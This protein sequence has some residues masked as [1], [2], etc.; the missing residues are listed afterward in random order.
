MNPQSEVL[1][2]AAATLPAP[3]LFRSFWMGGF[4]CATHINVF[5]QR[6]D[7]IAGVQHDTK[8]EEDYAL[9]K[10]VGMQTARDGLRWHLIEKTPGQYDWTSFTPML[11]AAVNQKVQVIWDL[12]HYGWP[13]DLDIFG[14]QFV[15]RFARF[16]RAAA[17]VVADHS[18]DVP[19]YSPVNEISFFS[20]AATRDFMYPFAHGR[21]NELKRQLVRAAI[22]A[23]SAIREV[24]ARA[25]FTFPE[26]LINVVVA[27]D[28][29]HRAQEALD[30]TASQF[31]VWDMLCGRFAPELGGA[32]E[33]LDII[34][35]NFYASNQWQTN[36]HRL[37]WE[38]EPRDPR[39]VPLHKMLA[40]LW[41]R[42]KRPFYL[43]ETSHIGV[44][45]ARWI[46]EI[47]NEIY[48]ARQQN[49]PI[50]GICLYPIL[51]RY[52]WQDENHWHNSGLWNLEKTQM[53]GFRRVAD[54]DYLQGFTR[55]QQQLAAIGCV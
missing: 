3:Q 42:Y 46:E 23:M 22:A 47:A 33:Y 15:D 52:D 50:E 13:H 29:P 4:E 18:D 39:W 25:R 32:P 6:L 35:V 49:I 11:Q 1:P 37:R 21:D 17:R 14:S 30:Y 38:E 9:L 2:G 40:D 54:P 48:T 44:G 12:C 26:P 16:A 10:T 20:W 55:A 24:D 45:R 53:S 51:D 31:E 28:E 27:P 34:G 36:A 7:M 8:A 41:K 5:N 19:F 43:A